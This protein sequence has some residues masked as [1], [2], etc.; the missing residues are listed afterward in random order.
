[1]KATWTQEG[2]TN[3]GDLVHIEKMN[4]VAEAGANTASAYHC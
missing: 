4:P 1:M 3:T 2:Q